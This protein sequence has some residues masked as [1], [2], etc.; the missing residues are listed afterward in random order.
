[1]R[2]FDEGFIETWKDFARGV[3]DDDHAGFAKRFRA[4]GFVGREKG[5]DY[6][7]QWEITRYLYTPFIQRDPYFTYTDEYVRKSYGLMLFENPN[8]RKTS[9]PAEWLLLNRLQWGLNAVLA[10]LGATAPWPDHFGRAARG[11]F[12]ASSPSRSPAARADN[13]ML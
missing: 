11:P 5:F 13:V 4:L 12:G 2:R 3:L 7:H 1:V 6:D 8:Q 10:K 9:C